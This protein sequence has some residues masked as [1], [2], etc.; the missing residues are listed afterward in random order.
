MLPGLKYQYQYQV[1]DGLMSEENEKSLELKR[2]G[3]RLC[4]I[5]FDCQIPTTQQL[6]P[7][8]ENPPAFLSESQCLQV[9]RKMK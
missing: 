1:F 7:V 8:L 6:C 4:V 2:E 5:C 3:W 9:W